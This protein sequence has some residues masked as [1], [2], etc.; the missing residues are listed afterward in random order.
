MNGVNK[1]NISVTTLLRNYF[2]KNKKC[3]FNI[4]P[5]LKVSFK[6]RIEQ[7]LRYHQNDFICNKIGYI[8]QKTDLS[9]NDFIFAIKDY[10]KKYY[11]ELYLGTGREKLESKILEFRTPMEIPNQII[12]KYK[13]NPKTAGNYAQRLIAIN[14][15]TSVPFSLGF[16]SEEN[17]Y[18]ITIPNTNIRI[19]FRC[20]LEDIQEG[21]YEFKLTKNGAF[22]LKL[23]EAICQLYLYDFLYRLKFNI[24][25]FHGLRI[26]IALVDIKKIY[27]YDLF[28]KKIG[29]YFFS[30]DLKEVNSF[31]QLNIVPKLKEIFFA[32][33]SQNEFLTISNIIDKIYCN[34]ETASYFDYNARVIRHKE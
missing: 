22:K 21:L 25:S 31:C 26:E 9:D 24:K 10:N 8:P 11:R 15:S 12:Q 19:S 18:F 29:K 7:I 1:M 34:I 16:K 3:D 30:M 27:I 14:P 20:D 6:K 32:N 28:E 17:N 33:L 13:E 2:K 5:I 23:K 4:I